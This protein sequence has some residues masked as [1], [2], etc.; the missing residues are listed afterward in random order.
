MADRASKGKDPDCMSA[1]IMSDGSWTEFPHDGHLIEC[2]E[3]GPFGPDL[4]IWGVYVVLC[5]NG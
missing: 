4:S 2:D 3:L 5:E 1:I